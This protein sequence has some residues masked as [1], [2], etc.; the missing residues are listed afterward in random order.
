MTTITKSLNYT[1][2]IDPTGEKHGI[3]YENSIESDIASL[4]IAAQV[5]TVQLGQWKEYKKA[6]A[7]EG[8]KKA[9]KNI[10]DVAA[11]LRGI[12]PLMNAL[13]NSYDEYMAYQ[14]Q[15]E[16]EKKEMLQQNGMIPKEENETL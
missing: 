7:G 3:S 8:K 13:L 2:E 15:M 10:S 11:A 9:S 4:M 16:A 14:A 1:L 5:L 6:A 12:K